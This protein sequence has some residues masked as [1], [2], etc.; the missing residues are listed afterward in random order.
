MEIEILN[1]ELLNLQAKKINV[2]KAREFP[3]LFFSRNV[4]LLQRTDE[5]IG[6]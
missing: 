1:F 2:K 5:L 4:I 6:V 3:G